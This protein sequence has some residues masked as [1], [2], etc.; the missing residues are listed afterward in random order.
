MTINGLDVKWG[1][2]F[3]WLYSIVYA[4]E[5]NVGEIDDWDAVCSFD[6]NYTY[7]EYAES[8]ALDVLTQYRVLESNH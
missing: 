6:E 8:Y 4:I 5:T 1:E 2:Y 7:R 3:Y